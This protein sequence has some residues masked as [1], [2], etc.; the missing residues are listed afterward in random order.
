M[1]TVETGMNT[2][3][4]VART[5]TGTEPERLFAKVVECDAG[6][7]DYQRRTSRVIPVVT[8]QRVE[9]GTAWAKGMGDF[10]VDS[11]NWLR[12]ELAGI[13]DQVDRIAAGKDQTMRTSERPLGA[14]LQQHCLQ[15]CSALKEHHDGEDDGAFPVLA[16][17]FPGLAPVIDRLVV[18][19]EVVH[20]LQDSCDRL[21]RD[22]GP[23]RRTRPGCAP[24]STG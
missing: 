23:V 22:I 20:E 12:T 7:G 4:A 21:S 3:E 24:G 18:E 16:Q 19:H 13:Q 5:P 2:Y 17:R 11:H 15:F 8:L 1:V 10:L 6:F 9:T 14:Q